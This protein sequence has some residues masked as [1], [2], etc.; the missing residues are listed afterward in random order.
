MAESYLDDGEQGHD[1]CLFNPG[2]IQTPTVDYTLLVIQPHGINLLVHLITR[3]T[4]LDLALTLPQG[5]NYKIVPTHKPKLTDALNIVVKPTQLPYF[6]GKAKD[7]IAYVHTD[8][9][10][11]Y[12]LF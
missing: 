11:L 6:I 9:P 3:Q 7:E 10:H 5:T 4:A 12:K 1:G 2:P 8:T